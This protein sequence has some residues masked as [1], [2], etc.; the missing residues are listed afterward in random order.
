MCAMSGFG[1]GAAS[2]A[3]RDRARENRNRCGDPDDGDDKRRRQE[4]C[5]RW[6]Y[7]LTV[8]QDFLADRAVRGVAVR[9]E[10]VRRV[11]L[12]RRSVGREVDMDL[13]DIGLKREGEQREK[14]DQQP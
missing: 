3:M 2:P 9:R 10:F 11:L 4:R 1:W 5:R 12:R 6:R 7:E 13:A 8:V 14:R